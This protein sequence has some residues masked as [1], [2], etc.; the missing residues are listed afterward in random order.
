MATLFGF[1]TENFFSTNLNLADQSQSGKTSALDAGKEDL[2]PKIIQPSSLGASNESQS[3]I[4]LKNLRKKKSAKKSLHTSLTQAFQAVPANKIS[5]K[6]TDGSGD[7]SVKKQSKKS[8]AKTLTLCGKK[9]RRKTTDQILLL[10]QYFKKDPCWTSK[11]VLEI[12]SIT[13]L[14]EAQIYKWGWDQKKKKGQADFDYPTTDEFGGYSKHGFNQIDS[15]CQAVGID[16]KAK[17][18]DI[19]KDLN[20]DQLDVQ[21]PPR[22]AIQLTLPASPEQ[23]PSD[24]QIEACLEEALMTP[25]RANRRL[26]ALRANKTEQK[27]ENKGKMTSSENITPVKS[28]AKTVETKTMSAPVRDEDDLLDLDKQQNYFDTDHQAMCFSPVISEFGEKGNFE[29]VDIPDFEAHVV[30]DQRMEFDELEYNFA[31][32]NAADEEQGLME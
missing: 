25:R 16:I 32:F 5:Q 23:E 9:R 28:Q 30:K 14:S 24:E 4:L 11:S 21:T 27:S 15:I 20:F 18:H 1:G 10:H 22:R 8:K 29:G 26:Q 7:A 13:G 17:L 31:E 19:T 12:Q 3:Q 6:S 2:K